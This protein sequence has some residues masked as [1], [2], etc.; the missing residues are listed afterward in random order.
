MYRIIKGIAFD[1]TILK[2]CIF[3]RLVPLSQ[4]D[5]G[6]LDHYVNS[7]FRL[8]DIKPTGKIDGVHASYIYLEQPYGHIIRVCDIRAH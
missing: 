3:D 4:I 7:N 6:P 1:N 8:R 2:L 5:W